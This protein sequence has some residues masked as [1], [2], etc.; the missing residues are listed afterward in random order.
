VLAFGLP[1]SLGVRGLTLIFAGLVLF[2]PSLVVSMI[3]FFRFVA[4]HYVRKDEVVT[5]LLSR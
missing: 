5:S 4:P 1:A 2:F 3:L